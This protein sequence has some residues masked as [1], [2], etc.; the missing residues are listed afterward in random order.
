MTGLEFIISGFAVWRLAHAVV[1]E[2]GPL[3]VFARFRAYLAKRQKRSGGMFDL[4]S[5]VYCTS[6]WVAL[7]AAMWA[8]QS[9][10]E[11]I[12]YALALSGAATLLEALFIKNTN[13]LTTVTG[14][15]RDNQIFISGSPTSKQRNYVIRH[16][17]PENRPLTIKT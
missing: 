5:C 8:A 15:T 11:L 6:F 17:D 2:N 4:I 3:M 9:L 13:A 10:V 14:P 1:K 16:P 7:F 12:W